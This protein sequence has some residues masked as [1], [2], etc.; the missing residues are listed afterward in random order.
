MIEKCRAVSALVF[1][2]NHF[3]DCH[4]SLA[5]THTTKAT[6]NTAMAE[7]LITIQA[8]NKHKKHNRTN[9]SAG[10]IHDIV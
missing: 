8:A 5:H 4:F 1:I 10:A 9:P 2:F 3:M 7:K 6:E